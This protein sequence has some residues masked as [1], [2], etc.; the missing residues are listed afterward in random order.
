MGQALFVIGPAG[1]GKTTFCKNLFSYGSNIGRSFK[2]INLDPANI[3]DQFTYYADIREFITVEDVQE[4]TD[5]G[6]NGSLLLALQEMS[7]NLEELELDSF[8]E[9]FLVFDCPGQIELFIHSEILS[10]IINYTKK[11]LKT[12]VLYLMDSFFL[13][14]PYKYVFG[15][16]TAYISTVKFQVPRLNVL[17]KLDL[18]EENVDIDSL[19]ENV[20]EALLKNEDKY[21]KMALR[22]FDFLDEN[23][24]VSFMKV[25]WEDEESLFE[26]IHSIDTLTEYW[27]DTETKINYPEEE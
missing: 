24:N 2:I 21:G 15:Y 19:R 22:I 4:S 10:N 1:S 13:I 12:T 3:D 9:D 20:K 8:Q 7:E 26:F 5:L 11:Y 25:D 14:D 23:E 16:L 6:P 18:L 17:T 27:E